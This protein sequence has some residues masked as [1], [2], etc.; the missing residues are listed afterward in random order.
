MMQTSLFSFTLDKTPMRALTWKEPFASL[1]LHGKIET[2][3]WPTKYRGEV[4]ICAGKQPYNSDQIFNIC[5][6]EQ[7][8]RLPY[9]GEPYG[10]RTTF[11]HAIAVG[12]LVDCRPM[13]PEDADACFV[14]YWKELYCHIYEN[15]RPI[16]PMPWKGSQGWGM[17]STFVESQIEYQ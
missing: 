10:K 16:K 8:K 4:L 2:R 7:L 12:T 14:E 17:V 13:R 15:V 1:M 3:T 6:A 9:L 11:G 5:G